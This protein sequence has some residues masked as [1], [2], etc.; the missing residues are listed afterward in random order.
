MLNIRKIPLFFAS[1]KTR[2]IIATLDKPSNNAHSFYVKQVL[3][4]ELQKSNTLKPHNRMPQID[5]FYIPE[6]LQ[7]PKTDQEFV[8]AQHVANKIKQQLYDSL[9][10]FTKVFINCSWGQSVL[11]QECTY[12]LSF[13]SFVRDIQYLDKNPTSW[14]GQYIKF[15]L[16]QRKGKIDTTTT[17]NDY[18]S[19]CNQINKLIHRCKFYEM[20]PDYI[21]N[22]KDKRQLRNSVISSSNNILP[23]YLINNMK[24]LESIYCDPQTQQPYSGLSI[25]SAIG[26]T[27]NKAFSI[28]SLMK[29]IQSV[30]SLS[31]PEFINPLVSQQIRDLK[32]TPYHITEDLHPR[33]HSIKEFLMNKSLKQLNELGIQNIR[34]DEE[35][36]FSE[37]LKQYVKTQIMQ[38]DNTI[39]DIYTLFIDETQANN[40]TGEL[41]TNILAVVD[42]NNII[43]KVYKYLEGT[44]YVVPKVIAHMVTSLTNV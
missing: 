24:L 8:Q 32:L 41:E 14:V 40:Q 6:E 20:N 13:R 1:S 28:N 23:K 39:K 25:Y 29:D 34:L 9:Q 17:F 12:S 11:N 42:Q 26:N 22:N 44:S 10:Q 21:L 2:V 35:E 43:T 36:G 33:I 38:N 3:E 27:C 15:H 30:G 31:N 5:T 16:L 4:T 19:K 18:R 37:A 7:N